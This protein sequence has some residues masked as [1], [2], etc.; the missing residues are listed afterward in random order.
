[1][2]QLVELDTFSFSTMRSVKKEYCIASH[3]KKIDAVEY[4]CTKISLLTH[5]KLNTSQN[6]SKVK[7]KLLILFSGTKHFCTTPN[8]QIKP[9]PNECMT[10]LISIELTSLMLRFLHFQNILDI[11]RYLVHVIVGLLLELQYKWY[12]CYTSQ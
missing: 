1:M 10:F 9:E 3:S 8:F 11:K 6:I 4:D 12:S 7:T 5:C 2:I